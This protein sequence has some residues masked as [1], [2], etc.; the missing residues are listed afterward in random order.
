[1]GVQVKKWSVLLLI[2]MLSACSG[3]GGE[4]QPEDTDSDGIVDSIDNCREVPN[5]SQLDEDGDGTG[6]ICDVDFDTDADGAKDSIDN[7]PGIANSN[8]ADSNQ[9]GIGNACDA[10]SDGVQDAQ[11]NCRFAANPSQSDADQDN[12][13]DAC[14]GFNLVGS[15]SFNRYV[16]PITDGVSCALLGNPSMSS[17]QFEV[18]YGFV[19]SSDSNGSPT[20]ALLVMIYCGAADCYELDLQNSLARVDANPPID[21]LTA[22]FATAFSPTLVRTASQSPDGYGGLLPQ[23]LTGQS[24]TIRATPTNQF[25]PVVT[26][27]LDL[28]GLQALLP[29]FEDC[30][31]AR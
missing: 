7:C 16:D 4:E 23:M 15:W 25:F 13:G 19:A 20:D 9:D 3:G 31:A 22:N 17:D 27:S 14:D 18:S 12:I 26:K 5:A 6:D 8:Q 2:A 28:T 1:M 29:A 30:A 21:I 11:D 10:D 24:V